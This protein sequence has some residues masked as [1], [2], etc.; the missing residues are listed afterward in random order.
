MA[1]FSIV[2]DMWQ[3]WVQLA[4]L[5]AITCLLRGNVGEIAA[6]PG[7]SGLA[8]AAL[9]ECAGIA[10]ASG[11]PQ[12]DTFLEK[13]TID[14]T[15]QGTQMTSSMYRDLKKGAPVEVDAIL[16]DL[17]ER[18]RKLDLKTPVL[19]AAFVHLSIYQRGLAIVG[20]QSVGAAQV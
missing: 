4:T 20:R 1:R 14:L 8:L 13:Q 5:G 9:R 7:G 3:K 6:I 2:K 18:G 17:L 15:A 11:Y 19:E 12:A 10:Q 16:G